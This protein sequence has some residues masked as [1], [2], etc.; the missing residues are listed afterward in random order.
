MKLESEA[1]AEHDAFNAPVHYL[2][3]QILSNR[4]SACCHHVGAALFPKGGDHVSVQLQ[5]QVHR[6]GFEGEMQLAPALNPCAGRTRRHQ[7]PML[8]LLLSLRPASV[9]A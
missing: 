1:A 6:A 8:D 4:C 3:P 5:T 9:E 2:G 7:G